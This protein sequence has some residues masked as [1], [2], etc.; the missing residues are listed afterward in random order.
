LTSSNFIFSSL[1]SKSDC[2]LSKYRVVYKISWCRCQQLAALSI[3]TALLPFVCT[4]CTIFIL[5]TIS[6]KTISHHAAAAPGPE[7]RH[8]LIS[9]F[10]P[11]RNKSWRRLWCPLLV[12][13]EPMNYCKS[14]GLVFNFVHFWLQTDLCICSISC[15][16]F[17]CQLH[18]TQRMPRAFQV[19]CSVFILKEVIFFL[20]MPN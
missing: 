15:L 20:H 8:D 17:C 14:T 5:I 2:Q 19:I 13:E 10:A 16:H 7:V 11:P 18:Y 3:T 9:S 6:H 4:S 12:C 1:W